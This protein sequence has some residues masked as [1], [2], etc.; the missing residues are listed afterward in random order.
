LS[1]DLVH[2]LLSRK[3]VKFQYNQIQGRH[4][5]KQ[6]IGKS[7]LRRTPRHAPFPARVRVPL[8][9]EARASDAKIRRPARE[10][11]DS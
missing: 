6:P 1:G 10:Y 8:Q 4:K 7:S 5:H 9:G 2:S 3:V 11:Y